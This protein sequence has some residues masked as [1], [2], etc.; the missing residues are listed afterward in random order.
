M[1]R[2]LVERNSSEKP[3]S[4]LLTPSAKW[5]LMHPSEEKIDL[6]NKT[7]DGEPIRTAVQLST[8]AFSNSGDLAFVQFNFRWSVHGATGSYLLQK[9]GSGWVVKC[10]KLFFA[11]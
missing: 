3:A 4:D 6:L 7:K 11:I 8:P 10:S 9:S 1:Y 5:R 2:A